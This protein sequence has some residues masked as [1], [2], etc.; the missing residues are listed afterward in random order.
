MGILNVTPDSFSEK[1]LYFDR[2]AAIARGLEIEREGADILD[3]GGES[4]RPG[5]QPVEEEEELDRTIP[6]IEALR[7][8]GLEI[9]IAIDTYKS[10]VAEQAL[11]AGAEIINDVSGLRYDPSLGD[12]TRNHKAAIVL[13]HLRGTPHT[14]QSLPPVRKIVAAI[15]LGLQ[16]SLE[17]AS[18]A[19]LR[20]NQIILDPGIGFGKSQEQNFQII[21]N[22]SDFVPLGWPILVGPSRKS[23][24]CKCLEDPAPLRVGKSKTV[25]EELVFGTAAAVTA[26]I[27]QGAHI[28]RVHDV[29]RMVVVA[30]IADQFLKG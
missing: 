1:G 29:S 26:S 11:R 2:K 25:A 4:T 6:V 22:L 19:G 12:V 15:R 27:L 17:R 14:M 3:I 18:K 24:I 23:F 8:K 5:S 20:K 28:V 21:A 30:R 10:K 16:A 9:P 13:M 7:R